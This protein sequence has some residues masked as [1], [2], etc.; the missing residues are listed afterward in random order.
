MNDRKGVI[1]VDFDG[2][3]VEHEFPK[4]G[5]LKPNAKEVLQ[6]LHKHHHI[7]IWTCRKGEYLQEALEFL[8][9]NNIP[10]DKANRNIDGIDFTSNKVY[11]DVYIDD[12]GLGCEINWSK[13]RQSIL[14][15]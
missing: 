5:P 6:E 9:E 13:I 11:A 7:I 2:T 12:R 15:R 1:A 8:K 10:F 3:I 4:I 14:G